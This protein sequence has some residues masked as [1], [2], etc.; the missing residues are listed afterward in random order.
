MAN[1]NLNNHFKKKSDIKSPV[2]SRIQ[3]NKAETDKQLWGDLRLDLKCNQIKQ[4]PLN[5]K[6]ST[7]D[8]QKVVNEQSVIVALRNIFNTHGCSRLLNPQMS[9]ELGTYL[10]QPLTQEKA[11]FLGYD[12]Y[13]QLPKW[14]PRVRISNVNV[15]ADIKNDCYIIQLTVSIP[16]VSGETFKI[17]SIL[18]ATGYS[19][20]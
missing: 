1:I 19:I 6:Q 2:D 15:I 10:F 17:S 12:I 16:N 14:Q 20:N 8:L 3:L 13:Q 5:A 9:F 18:S 4:R 7:K 11:W